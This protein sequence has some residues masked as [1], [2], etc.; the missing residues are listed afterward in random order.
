MELNELICSEKQLNIQKFIFIDRLGNPAAGRLS[1]SEH[2]N[3]FGQFTYP[4]FGVLS[5]P[6]NPPSSL[7]NGCSGK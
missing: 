4:T 2:H 5:K 7:R 3:Y 1:A 6:A